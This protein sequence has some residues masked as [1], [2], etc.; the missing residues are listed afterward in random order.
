MEKLYW[1]ALD[2][3]TPNT[4]WKWQTLN[5]HEISFQTFGPDM[6]SLDDQDADYFLLLPNQHDFLLDI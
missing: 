3:W 5:L 2:P 1:H 6:S 4:S